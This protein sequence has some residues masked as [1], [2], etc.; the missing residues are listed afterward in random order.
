MPNGY[1]QI[2][3]NDYGTKVYRY[4][5][6]L[7]AEVF[8][9]NPNNF[10]QVNHIDG[11]KT[12]NYVSNL[13]WVTISENISHAFRTGLN[14]IPQKERVRIALHARAIFSKKVE[15]LTLDG[16]HIRYWD[17][18][19]DAKRELGFDRSNIAEA[20]RKGTNSYGYKWKYI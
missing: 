18:A 7:V 11:C 5:H 1:E 10:P 3:L 13:E 20:C 12:H 19:C 14:E 4:I 6:R 15:Q 2:T 9:D 16:K 8:L 17:N